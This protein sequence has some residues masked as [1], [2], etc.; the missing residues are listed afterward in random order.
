MNTRAPGG[1][2]VASRQFQSAFVD[3][4]GQY[5]GPRGGVG[6]SQGDRAPAAPQVQEGALPG[7]VGHVIE[8]HLRALVEAVGAEY[9]RRRRHPVVD[10][11]DDEGVR[12]LVHGGVGGGG[13]VLLAHTLRLPARARPRPRCLLRARSQ[14]ALNL[15]AVLGSAHPPQAADF[16]H[17]WFPSE[18]VGAVELSGSGGPAGEQCR[19]G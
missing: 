13:E 19:E 9:A 16:V 18:W 5:A 14:P 17:T 4:G 8:E 15:G 7:R 11:A 10:S 1:G 3:I 6:Q 12:A 2:R